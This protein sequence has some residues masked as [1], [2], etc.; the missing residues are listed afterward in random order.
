MGF[1]QLFGQ[2]IKKSKPTTLKTTMKKRRLIFFSF[3]YQQVY[4]SFYIL[5][6]LYVDFLISKYLE[7]FL[8]HFFKTHKCCAQYLQLTRLAIR[9]QSPGY[10]FFQKKNEQQLRYE[11]NTQLAL[12]RI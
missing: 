12:R 6:C 8:C 4:S 10:L 11:I 5:M 7:R 1:G 2:T 9:S 3:F